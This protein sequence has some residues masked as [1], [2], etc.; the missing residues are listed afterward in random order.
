MERQSA[1]ESQVESDQS[2]VDELICDLVGTMRL[3]EEHLKHVLRSL[4]NL[5]QGSGSG[6]LFV[7]SRVANILSGLHATNEE[8][9]AKRRRLMDGKVLLQPLLM[10]PTGAGPVLSRTQSYLVL[11]DASQRLLKSE[12][13]RR[14]ACFMMRQLQKSCQVAD[15]HDSLPCTPQ[16]WSLLVDLVEDLEQDQLV[17]TNLESQ[18]NSL[19]SNSCD[20]G[21]RWTSWLR[22]LCVRLLKQ[23]SI[24]VRHAI[25]DY[26]LKNQSQ[27]YRLSL[28]PD[29]LRATNKTQLFDP[30]DPKRLKEQQLKDFVSAGNVQLFVEAL[31]VIPW[32]SVPLLYW[33]KCLKEVSF[34]IPIISKQLLEKLCLTIRALEDYNLRNKA[35]LEACQVFHATF[36]SLSLEGYMCCITAMFKDKDQCHEQYRLIDKIKACK[37]MELNLNIF[38][39]RSYEIFIS[40]YEGKNRKGQHD[41]RK[42]YFE[43]LRKVPKA[44]HGWWRLDLQIDQEEIILNFYRQIYD[45]DTSWLLESASLNDMQSYLVNKLECKNSDEAAFLKARCVDL[46]VRN[47]INSWSNLKEFNLNPS[48]LLAQG[49]FDTASTFIFLLG[50]H[51]EKLEEVSILETLISCSRSKDKANIIKHAAKYLTEEE[52]TKCIID[53]ALKVTVQDYDYTYPDVELPKSIAV[54]LIIEGESTTG[55]ER[56]EAAYVYDVLHIAN[57]KARARAF[58]IS[59]V[60]NISEAY[61]SGICDDLL[62]ANNE[63]STSPYLENSEVHIKKIRIA[64]ALVVFSE[65]WTWSDSLWQAALSPDDHPSITYMYECLVIKM[66]PNIEVLS[67]KLKLLTTLKR[68][69][70][71]SALAITHTYINI[72]R[73]E[74]R[75]EQLDDILNLVRP[76]KYH[77]YETL[78]EPRLFLRENFSTE[79]ILYV[80]NAPFDERHIF[81]ACE[82]DYYTDNAREAFKA[83]LDLYKNATECG[84]L[85]LTDDGCIDNTKSEDRELILVASLIDKISGFGALARTC[86]S[87]GVTSLTMAL[88]SHVTIANKLCLTAQQPLNIF[89]VRP[90]TLALFLKEKKAEGFKI[91]VAVDFSLGTEILKSELPKRCILLLKDRM[92]ELPTDLIDLLDKQF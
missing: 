87:L 60:L 18:L 91:F 21:E 6:E 36:D 3:N 80:T 1:S 50:R 33:L 45:V 63:L 13:R 25:L 61:L 44:Y 85:A 52:Y 12:N 51:T 14:S 54:N 28:L 22:I 23:E 48:E 5:L 10:N 57:F 30:E 65:Q 40:S 27:V 43:K 66:L 74:L 46:F 56:I 32:E 17:A 31:V 11:L 90:D 55:D 26:F 35:N 77:L 69:Q 53:R 89:V 20:L 78:N 2:S 15:E 79:S 59:A 49:T 4:H 19:F 92:S 73:K 75:K 37:E 67:E 47:R 34:A 7:S 24:L 16:Q 41:L 29:F 76:H 9:I 62:R 58:A 82:K 81:D 68:A 42:A 39:K 84:E 38:G 86:K 70:Q 8:N 64:T 83:K 88:K 71:E 72:H